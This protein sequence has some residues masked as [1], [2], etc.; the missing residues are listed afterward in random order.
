VILL[1]GFTGASDAWGRVIVDGLSA[2][3]HPPVMVELPGHGRNKGSSDPSDFSLDAA[4]LSISAAG[5]GRPGPLMGYSMGG[6]IALAYAAR[7]PE[8]VTRL[9]LESASPGLASEEERTARRA[10][11]E[12]LALRLE[13]WGIEAF[14][15]H[16]ESLP[17]FGSQRSLPSE[18]RRAHRARRLANDPRSLAAALRGLGTGALPSLW[19][20]LPGFEVPTLLI[21]GALDLKFVSVAERMASL[22]PDARIATVP[23][24]GHAVHL[25]RPGEW[26]AA[27]VG[28]L[29]D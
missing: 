19:D 21:V 8:R 13:S 15:D 25:E 1:H 2:A 20:A 22:L 9:V 14:V 3:G 12:E 6:R 16:W 4:C 10:S 11:D 24:A 5:D 18:T 29:A 28:F 26:L 27:V 17:I 23:G 7:H